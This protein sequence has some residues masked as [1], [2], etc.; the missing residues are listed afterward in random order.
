MVSDSYGNQPATC[1]RCGQGDAVLSVPDAYS[2]AAGTEA[3][4]RV[5]L[6]SDASI[7]KRQAARQTVKAAPRV[8][9]ARLLAVAPSSSTA[10]FGCLGVFFGIA[11]VA[12]L[13]F[14]LSSAR[15]GRMTGL[16]D[17]PWP[18]LVAALIA[19]LVCL[20]C[21]LRIPAAVARQRQVKAGQPAAAAIWSRAG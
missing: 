6:D 13:A 8:V 19:G 17:Q 16:G 11:A 2:S 21:I 9:S 5:L 4:R 20:L 15:S 14:Y 12:L 3:A 1:P 18:I 7:A 10:L